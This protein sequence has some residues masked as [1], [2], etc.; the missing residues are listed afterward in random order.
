MTDG[1]KI[2]PEL[3]KRRE[4]QLAARRNGSIGAAPKRID[5]PESGLD[6]KDF[7]YRVVN[8]TPGR[9]ERL[10]TDD[11]WELVP[12]VNGREMDFHVDRNTDGSSMR[13]RLLRKPREWYEEDQAA[14]QTQIETEMKQIK[15]GRVQSE[16]GAHANPAHTYVPDGGI[17]IQD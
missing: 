3:R 14:K 13:G 6:R 4:A 5:V 1:R 8:D 7:S 2:S 15:N 10:T 9:I 12:R 17:Q 11:T 16:S